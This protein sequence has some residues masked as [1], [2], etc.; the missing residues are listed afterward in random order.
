MKKS[1]L[2]FSL[3]IFTIYAQEKTNNSE[4]RWVPEPDDIYLQEIALKIKSDLPVTSIGESDGDCYTVIDNKIYRLDDE[5]LDCT[6]H[7]ELVG[8]K[9]STQQFIESVI[10]QSGG[11]HLSNMKG[12]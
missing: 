1:I 8:G 7:L 5:K 12:V 4:I 3:F 6:S 10:I 11:E 9:I 2:I